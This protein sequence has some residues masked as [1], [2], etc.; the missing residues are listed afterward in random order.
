MIRVCGSR[1]GGH[2]SFPLLGSLSFQIAA[3]AMTVMWQLLFW[4][5]APLA[6]TSAAKPNPCCRL[7]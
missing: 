7:A 6:M 1:K 3:V 2:L 5:V 4:I